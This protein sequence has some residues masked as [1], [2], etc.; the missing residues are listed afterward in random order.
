MGTEGKVIKC[1][2]AVA[3]EPRKPLSLEEVEVAP[4]KAHEVRIKIV[5][6]S[7]CHSDLQVLRETPLPQGGM[8]TFPILLGHEAAGIVES[9]GPGVTKFSKGDTVIPLFAAQCGECEYC[10]SPKTNMCKTHWELWVGYV[11]YVPLVGT[12]ANM[13]DGFIALLQGDRKTAEAK[14]YKDFLDSAGIR[15]LKPGSILQNAKSQTV[16]GCSAKVSK[17]INDYII[18]AV[19]PGASHHC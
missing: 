18:Q 13:V 7:V 5:A 4:P 16:V 14:G 9:I 10:L 6:T 17:D 1:K 3:W 12:S 11:N 2:A 19:K 8:H 15:D